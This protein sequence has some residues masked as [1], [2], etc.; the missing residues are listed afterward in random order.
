M[1]IHT[2]IN[3]NTYTQHT[4]NMHRKKNWTFIYSKMLTFGDYLLKDLFPFSAQFSKWIFVTFIRK[5]TINILHVYII[6]KRSLGGYLSYRSLEYWSYMGQK[7]TEV[8]RINWN[9]SIKSKKYLQNVLN[10]FKVAV[11]GVAIPFH[12]TSWTVQTGRTGTETRKGDCCH[13]RRLE[14]KLKG[15]SVWPSEVFLMFSCFQSL[16]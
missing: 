6:I 13:G 5:R 11:V 1:H 2:H 4:H 15:L 16:H 8:Q 10:M 7:H 12:K 3:L 14:N 9:N